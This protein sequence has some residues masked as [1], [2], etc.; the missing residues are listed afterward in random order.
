MLTEP[1]SAATRAMHLTS[2][3][4]LLVNPKQTSNQESLKTF[5]WILCHLSLAFLNFAWILGFEVSAASVVRGMLG[6][7][8]CNLRHKAA[9]RNFR[10]LPGRGGVEHFVRVWRR[11]LRRVDEKVIIAVESGKDWV[12]R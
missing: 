6:L 11:T 8:I 7:G 4:A 9:I 2:P 12:L 5:E 3:L 1:A 10:D